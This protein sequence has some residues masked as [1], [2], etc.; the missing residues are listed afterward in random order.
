MA[1]KTT[2]SKTKNKTRPQ[3]KRNAYVVGI[4]V[5]IVLAVLTIIEYYVAIL[6]E[7]R[8]DIMANQ[9]PTALFLIAFV[10]AALVVYFFMHV[11]RLW[12]PDDHA[13]EGGH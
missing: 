5:A 1:S 7:I 3:K 6:P 4:V 13:D 10:K 2:A 12:R 8:P 11:Y 9:S